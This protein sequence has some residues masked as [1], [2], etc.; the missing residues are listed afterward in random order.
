[1]SV[2]CECC[3][4]SGRG[5][6]DGLITR[7]EESYRLCCVVMH[8]LETSGMRRP[9]PIGGCG[10]KNTLYLMTPI[11]GCSLIT[12]GACV[13]GIDFLGEK[14]QVTFILQVNLAD[15]GYVLAHTYTCHTYLFA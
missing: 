12:T 6:C 1:V 7:L 15:H 4:L 5:L 2:R 9:W 14:L 13:S 3:V 10:A 11:H 8:D